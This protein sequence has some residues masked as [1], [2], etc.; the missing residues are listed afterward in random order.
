MTIRHS[1]G[2]Y[3]IEF[4]SF[5]SLTGSLPEDCL[6]VSDSNVLEHWRPSGRNVLEVAP[7]EHEKN[8]TNLGVLLESFAR[9]GATRATT[10]VALGGGVVGDLAGFAASAYMR[11]VPCIQVP[12]TLLAMV[13][14]SVGGK[15]GV[16]LEAGKNLAGAFHPPIA[17][18]IALETL[19]TLPQRQFVNGTA[20]VWKA[21]CILDERLFETLE[22]EPLLPG[23]SRIEHV[24]RRCIELKAGV[25][26]ADEFETTG[27]RAI[28]NFGH[29]VGHALEVVSGYRDMLH[30]EAVAVGMVVEATLGERLGTT[31]AGLAGRVRAA[32]ESQGLPTWSRWLEEDDALLEAMRHDK[33]ASRGELAFSLIPSLGECKL[34][35]G[36]DPLEVRAALR[37]L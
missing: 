31:E 36:V 11:G 33:K 4:A 13:D 6:V 21:G 18:W 5:E 14:S 24:V 15:V 9:H 16:D 37:S 7:G 29:T 17:V 28:L 32:L 10:I 26:A 30:G 12:T 20:E 8:L 35:R 34:V 19:G 22:A 25:V 1:R 23:D 27:A 2:T 3:A